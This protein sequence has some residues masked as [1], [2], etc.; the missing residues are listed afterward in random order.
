MVCDDGSME[1]ALPDSGSPVESEAEMERFLGSR[2][3]ETAVHKW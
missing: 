1:A 3:A 2:D